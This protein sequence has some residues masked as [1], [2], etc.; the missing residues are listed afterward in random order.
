MQFSL[1]P[2]FDR[3]WDET[4]TLARFAEQ[5]GYHSFWFADHLMPNR[6]DGTPDPGD[7][8]ECWTVLSA[9][10]ALVP[11][12]RLVS[13]VSPVTIHH[14]V[15]LAKRATT[16]SHISGGRAVLGLGA[17]WQENEHAAYGFELPAP[18]PRV[19]RFAEAIE[20]VHRLLREESV[21]FAGQ[22]YTLTDA[23]FAPK[24]VGA[25]PL[26]VGTGSPRML[27]L[28]ARFAD[29]WNTWGDPTT[30]G[31]R[32][33]AF[34]A[35]CESVGRDPESLRRSSQAL[36]FLVN[37]PAEREAHAP[38][39]ASGRALIG[40]A[41]ELVQLLG[42]YA[43]LGVHE[44]AIPDFTLGATAAERA[45]ALAALHDQVFSQLM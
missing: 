45:D 30:V 28:T 43:D 9:I 34:L 29:E 22:Y 19:S 8:L 5:H 42:A 11:R 10:A 33:E 27:R 41:D 17:G 38:F 16:V 18:G 24:P 3:S 13:M 31:Q 7:T 26:L 39:A 25:L 15:L 20:I 40:S 6:P 23:P 12:V 35:A 14:P 44:F 2:S 37:T 36:V 1:W 32:T 21:S 4:L